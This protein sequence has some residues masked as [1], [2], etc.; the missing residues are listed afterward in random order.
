VGGCAG[1]NNQRYAT[2]ELIENVL[3]GRGT[4]LTET[5][6]ARRGHR[7]AKRSNDFGKNR[8]R[9]DSNGDCVQTGGDN[10][11]NDRAFRQN[12]RERARPESLRQFQN[13]SSILSAT[14]RTRCGERRKIDNPFEPI[15]IR[16]MDN[17]RIEARPFLCFE[18]LDDRF[19]I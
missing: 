18:N 8:M 9:T 19:R 3:R 15:V 5:I 11:G 16:Q 4:D 17:Q 1:I 7:P 14:G 2:V 10:F 13:D 12:D 6:R